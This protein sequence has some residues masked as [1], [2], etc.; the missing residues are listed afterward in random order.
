MRLSGPHVPSAAA[1]SPHSRTFENTPSIPA[2]ICSWIPF[3]N[4]SSSLRPND[5]VNGLNPPAW[6]LVVPALND[7]LNCGPKQFSSTSK[8]LVGSAFGV[9]GVLHGS[10][11]AVVVTG[12]H[13]RGFDNVARSPPCNVSFS[14]LN[15]TCGTSASVT[16]NCPVCWLI[17]PSV[18]A[19]RRSPI[20]LHPPA[21]ETTGP[22][23]HPPRP[24]AYTGHTTVRP[25]RS[26]P[27]TLL[28]APASSS[29]PSPPA[30]P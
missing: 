21:A 19:S 20:R 6:L 13:Q 4:S 5:S 28:Q 27:S 26:R 16:V 24:R 8:L 10:S 2:G 29:A 18:L 14:S 30:N 25:K 1:G 17:S 11:S 3:K 15:G 9:Y 7:G 12:P 22:S 23:C